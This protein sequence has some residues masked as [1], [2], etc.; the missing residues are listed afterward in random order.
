MKPQSQ[1][2]VKQPPNCSKFSTNLYPAI[3]T[4]LEYDNT[5][6]L[7]RIFDCRKDGI[8]RPRTIKDAEIRQ[9]RGYYPIEMKDEMPCEAHPGRNE[10]DKC[11][12]RHTTTIRS[13]RVDGNVLPSCIGTLLNRAKLR[14]CSN[15]FIGGDGRP[16]P[17]MICLAVDSRDG[18]S[19][20]TSSK[21][22]AGAGVPC[23][24]RAIWQSLR[25]KSSTDYYHAA[26]S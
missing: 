23:R 6:S 11:Y 16:Q 8:Q 4:D 9:G 5:E 24:G 1:S 19:T 10:K 15:C 12:N 21:W 22:Y 2:K 17:P 18:V 3:F 25:R 14:S 20:S 7:A 26:K 13:V